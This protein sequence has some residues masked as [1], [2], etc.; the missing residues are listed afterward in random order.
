MSPADIN[1]APHN[2]NVKDSKTYRKRF[3]TAFFKKTKQI[4]KKKVILLIQL[5]AYLYKIL[6]FPPEPDFTVMFI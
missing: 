2:R 5:S 1:Q 4:N 3:S 6:Y